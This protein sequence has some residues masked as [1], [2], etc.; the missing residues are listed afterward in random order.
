MEEIKVK[1]PYC[2]NMLKVRA[3]SR[4][5]IE[6][7]QMM[8]PVCKQ[9]FPFKQCVKVADSDDDT[10]YKDGEDRTHLGE[11][12]NQKS[13]ENSVIGILTVQ[14]N[15]KE[16][17]NLKIGRNVVG[18]KASASTADIQIATAENR[19][20]S[21]KHVVIEVKKIAGRGMVHYI[22]LYKERLNP[23]FIGNEK[24]EYGD[25]LELNDGDII[26]LPD[27]NLKFEI[28]DE[29]GTQFDYETTNP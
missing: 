11:T 6:N 19:R 22:S 5:G 15:G 3:K 17:Y 25:V 2:S 9:K 12:A 28:P 7:V 20:M 4:T 8:C 16:T 21:R 29:E 23:T 13:T 27:C 24:M 26:R 1:C 14:G 10:K 18:R